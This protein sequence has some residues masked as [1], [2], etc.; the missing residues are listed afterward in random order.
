MFVQFCS[1]FCR[2]LAENIVHLLKKYP[3]ILYDQASEIKDFLI[4]PRNISGREEFFANLVE[5]YFFSQ[6]CSSYWENFYCV[7]DE[8]QYQY[9]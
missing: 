7:L 9:K 5:F 8:N 2:V 6:C 3:E 1:P 4:S